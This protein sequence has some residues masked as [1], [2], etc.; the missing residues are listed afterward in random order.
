MISEVRT[1]STEDVDVA[2]MGCI[3]TETVCSSETLVST[4]KFTRC[5]NPEDQH[6]HKVTS[7]I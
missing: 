4:Y 6:R 2:L 3:A 5:H 7:E 1:H